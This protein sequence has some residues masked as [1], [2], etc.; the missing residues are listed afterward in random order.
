[1][2]KLMSK[3]VKNFNKKK[4]KEKFGQFNSSWMENFLLWGILG[5]NTYPTFLPVELEM[6]VMSSFVLMLR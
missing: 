2:A 5:H 6:S 1:M 3:G 4:E